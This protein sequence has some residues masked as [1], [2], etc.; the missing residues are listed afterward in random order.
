MQNSRDGHSVA[1][2]NTEK[3]AACHAAQRD[4]VVENTRCKLLRRLY[5]ENSPRLAAVAGCQIGRCKS[6]TEG[7]YDRYRDAILAAH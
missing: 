6:G 4:F 7:R 2:R 1:R 3:H 5:L